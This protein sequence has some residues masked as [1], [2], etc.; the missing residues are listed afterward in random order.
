MTPPL[1]R[2]PL[3][4]NGRRPYARRI[5][6]HFGAACSRYWPLDD[7][8]S[9]R[10]RELVKGDHGTRI[11]TTVDQ[12]GPAGPATY[13]DGVNDYLNVYSESLA[14]DFDGNEGAIIMWMSCDAEAWTDG[15]YR[16]FLQFPVS[17]SESDYV[18]A[19]KSTVDN[20]LV[21]LFQIYGRTILRAESDIAYSGFFLLTFS[22][23]QSA[24]SVY[25]E[26]RG[27]EGTASES[28]AFPSGPNLR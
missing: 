5:L 2:Y 17:Q 14:A 28:N 9:T 24:N 4:L 23:S 26:V 22:W 12:A 16:N 3:S 11:G 15:A 27:P 18:F 7:A 10:V 13:F 21:L 8:S 20:K 1:L 19:Y 6:R 25:M